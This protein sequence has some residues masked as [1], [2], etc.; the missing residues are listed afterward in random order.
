MIDA[1]EWFSMHAEQ[2][3]EIG[4]ET[5]LGPDLMHLAS[6]LVLRGLS[7]DE[8]YLH[9]RLRLISSDGERDHLARAP[10][11]LERIRELIA[12]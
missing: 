11:A 3:D 5:E 1:E 12:A 7:D 10:H 6:A 8:I 4:R 2:L 9:L